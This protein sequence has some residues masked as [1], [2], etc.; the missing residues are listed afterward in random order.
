[1]RR[2]VVLLQ[3]GLLSLLIGCGERQPSPEV[4][5]QVE[6]QPSAP[7]EDFGTTNVQERAEED[8]LETRMAYGEKGMVVSVHPIAT[9]VGLDVLKRGGNAI[10]AA[11]AMGLTLGVVDS[12]NSGIGGGCFILI[13]RANGAYNAI[14]GRET[15]PAAATRD[16]YIRN[17]KADPELSQ[18]GPL[19][20]ATPG[21][22]HAYDT[23]VRKFGKTKLSE[24]LLTAA[25]IAEDGF[26]VNGSFAT[27]NRHTAEK[28]AK[29][30]DSRRIFLRDGRP[31]KAGD[32]LKQPDLAKTYRNIASEGI[33]YFYGGPFAQVTEEWMKKNGG[34]L[35]ASDFKNYSS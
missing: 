8:V 9:Q 4:V 18:T 5:A 25:K 28:L 26:P 35:T 12:H 20:I 27:V 14:D 33:G 30:E 19:A 7:T 11:V 34:I 22:L 10:D 29:F 21:A 15:A 2:I 23:A 1:M 32:I 16:M 3:I 13:R 17:G 6:A 24:H 31:L